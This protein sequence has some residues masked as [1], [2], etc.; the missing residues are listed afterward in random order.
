MDREAWCAAVHGVTK[1]Q[2]PLS[3]WIEL[4]WVADSMDHGS[5]ASLRLPERKNPGRNPGSPR[6]WLHQGW[7][8]WKTHMQMTNDG[9][10]DHWWENWDNSR[11]WTCRECQD[12][13]V[14]NSSHAATL[15]KLQS[16]DSTREWKGRGKPSWMWFSFQQW[17]A[18][19]M[20]DL[21]LFEV[22]CH[23][24]KFQ[25]RNDSWYLKKKRLEKDLNWWIGKC[26]LF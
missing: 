8:R 12:W 16:L 10:R 20:S 22:F 5:H 6:I 19:E 21:S 17:S 3:D 4:N 26:F 18:W 24:V 13:G 23:R 1:S 11:G 25:N 7:Q 9:H 2:T 14:D 15:Q